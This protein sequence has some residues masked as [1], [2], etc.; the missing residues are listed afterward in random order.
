MFESLRSR[1][2]LSN[3]F[4]VLLGLVAVV[5]VSTQL[6]ANRSEDLSRAKLKQQSFQVAAE[7]HRLFRTHEKPGPSFDQTIRS[8]SDVLQSRIILRSSSGA[9]IIDTADQ[10]PFISGSWHPY[11]LEA[12]KQ[13][14]SVAESLQS[15]HLIAFQ[16]PIYGSSGRLDG[17]VLVVAKLKDVRPDLGSMI[18]IMLVAIATA[19]LAW[20]AIGMYFAISISR[21]LLRVQE[22]TEEMA[23]GNYAVQVPVRGHTE[24]SQ[25]AESFNTMAQQVQRSNQILR[26]FVANVSHDLRTPLTLITGFSQALLDGTAAQEEADLSAGMIHDEAVKM[27]HLVDDLLQLTRLESGLLTL[28]R[29]A[30]DVY[31]FVEGTIDRIARAHGPDQVPALLNRVPRDTPPISADSERLERILRNLLENAIEYTPPEGE[32]AV[33]A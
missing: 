19:L 7:I 24:I 30:V 12:L 31:S 4:I 26:D 17:A 21:P 3:L 32:I 2:A 29:H 1:L 15:Q 20:L 6:I 10:T 8:F 16:A 5:A 23:R 28:D 14:R 11:D 27:Q 9:K 33:S 25:L 22:G 18:R 13:G